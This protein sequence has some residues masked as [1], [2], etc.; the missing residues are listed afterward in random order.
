[1]RDL[2]R[3]CCLRSGVGAGAP[4]LRADGV[5][6]HRAAL[7]ELLSVPAWRSCGLEDSGQY[8]ETTDA[9]LEPLVQPLPARTQ[10]E[11]S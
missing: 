7:P 9:F 3:D 5:A 8:S 2:R 6:E 11:V 1:M 4:T 10:A